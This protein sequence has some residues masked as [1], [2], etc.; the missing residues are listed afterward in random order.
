VWP[1]P[2]DA[3][4]PGALSGGAGHPACRVTDANHLFRQSLRTQNYT[5]SLART[6]HRTIVQLSQ[7]CRNADNKKRAAGW[8]LV[9]G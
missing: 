5:L 2:A 3:G 7:F 9:K 4:T 6:C 8:R 1:E